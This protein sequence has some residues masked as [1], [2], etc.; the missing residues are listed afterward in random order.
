MS[1]IWEAVI[2]SAV[3]AGAFRAEARDCP[4][5]QIR[6]YLRRADE[7]SARASA[8]MAKG[9]GTA[10]GTRNGNRRPLPQH[11]RKRG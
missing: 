10:G 6:D 1:E 11:V 3:C 9:V 2:A 4:R 7:W 5:S 8:L